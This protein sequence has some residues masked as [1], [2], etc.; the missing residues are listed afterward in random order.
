MGEAYFVD[1][2]TV[3]VMDETSAQTYNF[4]N[5]IIATGSRPVEIPT[6]KYTKRVINS[7]GAL[8]LP[9]IPKNLVV[10]GG[11]YIGTELRVS[12]C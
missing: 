1:A 9:E 4:K 6:F 2:N 8:S 10:I 7:T 5:A 12:F 3:R 11:G